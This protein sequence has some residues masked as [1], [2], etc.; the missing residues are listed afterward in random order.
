MNSTWKHFRKRLHSTE[1]EGNSL[2]L[3]K[4]EREGIESPYTWRY[5]SERGVGLFEV[6][7]LCV[8]CGWK[9]SWG[10]SPEEAPLGCALLL[11]CTC[12]R[13][14]SPTPRDT[15][16][17]PPVS[18][19]SS[20]ARDIAHKQGSFCHRAS[21]SQQLLENTQLHA[22]WSHMLLVFWVCFFNRFMILQ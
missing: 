13:Y 2:K 6:V 17:L 12:C 19:S 10:W 16:L 8:P 22:G 4:E 11:A 14:A 9:K 1:E 20:G 18:R 7:C 3:A 21:E 15:A 5:A